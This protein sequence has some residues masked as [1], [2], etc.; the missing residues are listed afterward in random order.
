MPVDAPALVPPALE[1]RRVHPHDQHIPPAVVGCVREVA[2]ETGVAA[3]VRAQDVAVEPYRAVAEDAVELH[4]QALP[5]VLGGQVEALAVPADRAVLEAV[6]DI[7]A[8]VEGLLDHEVV[9]QVQHAPAAVIE[10]WRGRAAGLAGLDRA[11]GVG[12]VDRRAGLQV[13]QLKAPAGVHQQ[14]GA[15]VVHGWFSCPDRVRVPR[16]VR[17]APHQSW[18][19]SHTARHPR[20]IARSA[21]VHAQSATRSPA[22]RAHTHRA[23]AARRSG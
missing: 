2:V 5:E 13:A 16:R 19:P 21:S 6:T 1:R 11:V 9:G 3:L 18:G 10:A 17:R 23:C 20:P 14:A 4:P 15:K 8:R 7:A 12:M 22:R